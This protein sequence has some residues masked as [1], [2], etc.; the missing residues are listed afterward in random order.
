MAGL[1]VTE[2]PDDGRHEADEPCPARW[3]FPDEDGDGYTNLEEYLN[4]TDPQI[5]NAPSAPVIRSPL[6]GE[7]TT[8]SHANTPTP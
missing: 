4:N 7:E 3:W 5:S 2:S 1:A 8:L 6:D